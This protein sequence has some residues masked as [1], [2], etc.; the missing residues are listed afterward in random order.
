MTTVVARLCLDM[1][2]QRRARSSR[3]EG[4]GS[5]EL[6]LVATG[7]GIEPEPELL[8][9]DSIGPALLVV[10]DSLAPAERLAFVLH[11]MFGVPFEEIGPMVGRSTVGARQLASRARRR[12]RGVGEADGALVEEGSGA[13]S[14]AREREIVSAFLTAS[15]EGDLGGLIALLDP[16]VVLRADASA[17][18][19]ATANQAR[20]APALSSEVRGAAAVAGTF[21]GRARGTRVALVDGGYGGVFAVRGQPWAVFGFSIAGG[22]VIEIEIIV[23]PANIARMELT[24]LPSAERSHEPS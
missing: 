3:E 18:E 6:R 24:M 5:P 20:G 13:G 7:E 9:A 11:D 2:R 17:V 21:S 14:S 23:D 15:R 10:L 1:L 19:A 4:L 16:D 8:L 22:K 12:A